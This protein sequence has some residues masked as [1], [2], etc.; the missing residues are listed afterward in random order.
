MDK[1]ENNQIL[2]TKIS[3]RFP[4]TNKLFTGKT[5]SFVVSPYIQPCLV[6]FKNIELNN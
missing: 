4:V 2:L 3:H 6:I 5:S 1:I